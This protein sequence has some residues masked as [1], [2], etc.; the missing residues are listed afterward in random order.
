MSTKKT[1]GGEAKNK[2]GS[3]A[4]KSNFFMEDPADLFII[5]DPSNPRFD[6]RAV[7]P[8][9]QTLINSIEVSGVIKPVICCKNGGR[10]EVLDGR[11]RVRA[12]RQINET[13]RG[14]DK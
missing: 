10:A 3:T 8:L 5:T 4:P 9:S 1:K 14:E 2:Q 11:Q 7:M 6:E 12:A 13:R